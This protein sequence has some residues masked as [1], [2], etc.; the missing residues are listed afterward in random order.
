MHIIGFLSQWKMYLD[1]LPA[2]PDGGKAFRG[3]PLDPTTLEKVRYLF[4]FAF[5]SDFKASSIRRCPLSSWVNYTRL[6][7]LRRMFGNL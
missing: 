3:K 1:A 5:G 6:C 2:G 7:T 4:A